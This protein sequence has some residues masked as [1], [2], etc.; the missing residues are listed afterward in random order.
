L[1]GDLVYDASASAARPGLAHPPA[2]HDGVALTGEARPIGSLAL[3]LNVNFS[4]D[5]RR[6]L[7]LSRRPLAQAGSS[8]RPS[9]ATSTTTASRRRE[10]VEKGAWSRPAPQAEKA[11]DS[12]GSVTVPGSPPTRR[13]RSGIDQSS[14]ADPMLV[15]KARSG[16]GAAPRR[17]AEVEIGLVGGG[18]IEGAIVKSG[19]SASKGSTSSWS[20]RREWSRR[21]GP[22]STASS[23]SSASPYGTIACASASRGGDAKI[24]SE[25]AARSR[26]RRQIDRQAAAQSRCARP[27]SPHPPEPRAP[28][29]AS[30]KCLLLRRDRN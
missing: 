14:L 25:L 5:P 23:C 18:D 12:R 1:G 21:R 20:T 6:G 10:P 17:P 29:S 19:G 24:G 28:K 9:T 26:S 4:L 16:G 27:S 11:T 2:R 3:G 13:S 15:P 22:I 8:A 30:E 7:S